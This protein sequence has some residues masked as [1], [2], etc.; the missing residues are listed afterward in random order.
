LLGLAP[1]PAEDMYSG[2]A[3][4]LGMLAA[5]TFLQYITCYYKHN[6]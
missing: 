4:A 6:F 3:E 1:G 5:L 2:Q